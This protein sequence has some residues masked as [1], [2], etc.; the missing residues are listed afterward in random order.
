MWQFKKKGSNEELIIFK[1]NE[2]R[3]FKKYKNDINYILMT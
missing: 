3:P 2:K 1:I